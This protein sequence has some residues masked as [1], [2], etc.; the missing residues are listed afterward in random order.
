VGL[1]LDRCA[2]TAVYQQARRGVGGDGLKDDLRE[3]AEFERAEVFLAELD[4]VD[5]L[6]P[7]SRRLSDEG[8]AFLGLIAGEE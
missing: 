3:V 5:R 8:G 6:F 4:E 7:P 2:Q 1:A